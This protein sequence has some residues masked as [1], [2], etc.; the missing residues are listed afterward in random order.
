MKK[1]E[2]EFKYI[3]NCVICNTAFQPRSILLLGRFDDLSE[4]YT[5]CN[6]CKSSFF[7]YLVRAKNKIN[8]LPIITDMSKRDITRRLREMA[9]ITETEVKAL[10]TAS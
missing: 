4:M 10:D 6:K 9:P 3:G 1:T 2:F 5:Q 7:V 8:V